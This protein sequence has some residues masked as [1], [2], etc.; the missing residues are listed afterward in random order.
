MTSGK[1]TGIDH[2]KEAGSLPSKACYEKKAIPGLSKAE[3]SSCRI[4]ESGSLVQPT[5]SSVVTSRMI[6]ENDK[7]TES[8]EQS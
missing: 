3:A 4:P 5:A 8:D 1:I 7:V 2:V 6:T